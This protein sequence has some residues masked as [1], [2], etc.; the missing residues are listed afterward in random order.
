MPA[1]T[2]ATA[3][4]GMSDPDHSSRG[5]LTGLGGPCARASAFTCFVEP[6]FPFRDPRRPFPP[7][8]ACQRALLKTQAILGGRSRRKSSAT[9]EAPRP[10]NNSCASGT[11]FADFTER[12]HP[13]A[14]GMCALAQAAHGLT[15]SSSSS[16][17]AAQLRMRRESRRF[18]MPRNAGTGF[19]S[20]GARAPG[21]FITA[22]AVLPGDQRGPEDESELPCFSDGA[23]CHER[24][25][26][27]SIPQPAMTRGRLYREATLSVPNR[28]CPRLRKP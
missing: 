23:Q 11:Y 26:V 21:A 27:T 25:Q 3:L 17:A 7:A 22:S 1:A 6:P 24:K 13:V 12:Q 2:A 4:P 14:G 19:R 28:S 18:L 16:P 15:P 10:P 5:L 20:R 9:H 8:D